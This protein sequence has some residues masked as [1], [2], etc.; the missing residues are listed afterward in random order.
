MFIFIVLI[1]LFLLILFLYKKFKPLKDSTILSYSGGLGKGKS[2]CMTNKA[3]S[4][5]HK[6]VRRWNRVNKPLFFYPSVFIPYLRKKRLRSE[7]WGLNKPVLYANYPIRIKKGVYSELITN[8]HMFLRKGMAFNNITVIDEFSSWISQFEFNEVFSKTLNDHI[9]KWRHYHGNDSHLLVSDQCTN[10]IP[11]QIR[12]RMNSCILCWGVQHYF[13]FIHI[14]SY[15]EIELSDDIKTIE[16]NDKEE[17]A[18]TED[19]IRKMLIFSFSRK[20]DDR[21]FSNRYCYVENAEQ[22]LCCKRID[23][24]LKTLISIRQPMPKEKYPNLDVEILKES[25]NS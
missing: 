1:L 15:K 13:K 17:D 16:I 19:K 23:S 21:A 10:N 5:Y 24:P 3:L 25:K 7:I 22:E 6:S 2:F 20:Y 18:V 8:D 14:V 4:L 12:Y 11:I 9:Q